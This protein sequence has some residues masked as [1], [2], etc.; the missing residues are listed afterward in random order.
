MNEDSTECGWRIPN[1]LEESVLGAGAS[2]ISCGAGASKI[3]P[4]GEGQAC[5]VEKAVRGAVG[6]AVG[7]AVGRAVRGIEQQWEEHW[8]EQWK[9]QWEGTKVRAC[10]KS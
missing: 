9:E 4:N 3:I 7:A 2:R 1:Q 5:S 6:R 10:A 8:E